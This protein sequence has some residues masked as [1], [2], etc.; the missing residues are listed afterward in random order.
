MAQRR[1]QHEKWESILNW[2]KNSHTREIAQNPYTR[3]EE[4]PDISDLSF[5]LKKL[6]KEQIKLKRKISFASKKWD[7][8]VETNEA[9]NSKIENSLMV[10]E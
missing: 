9:E 2:M 10:L 3:K 6:E 8:E 1:N 7:N 4:R 5:Y